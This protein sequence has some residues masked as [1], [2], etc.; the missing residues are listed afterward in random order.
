MPLGSV[1]SPVVAM[2]SMQAVDIL[3]L[4]CSSLMH[5][6]RVRCV[7]GSNHSDACLVSGRP[8]VASKGIKKPIIL[9]SESGKER[10]LVRYLTRVSGGTLYFFLY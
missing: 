5:S 6:G 10:K 9:S 3:W 7:D 8:P 1:R 4:Q 2:L